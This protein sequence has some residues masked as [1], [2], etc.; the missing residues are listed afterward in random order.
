MY[1]LIYIYIYIDCEDGSI[2]TLSVSHM[3][4]WPINVCQFGEK[5]YMRHIKEK[6]AVWTYLNGT[7]T[8]CD[9]EGNFWAFTTYLEDEE[10][11]R[12]TSICGKCKNWVMGMPGL[13]EKCQ[14]STCT[15][16]RYEECEVCKQPTNYKF[17]DRD[18]KWKY[19]YDKCEGNITIGMLSFKY[20]GN[21][22]WQCHLFGSYTIYIYIYIGCR[23]G[24]MPTVREDEKYGE[25]S[26]FYCKDYQCDGIDDYMISIAVPGTPGWKE[27]YIDICVIP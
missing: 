9:Q 14:R 5:D 6:E 23:D 20:K 22:G 2:L 13:L 19:C 10:R 3:D 12:E 4:D 15:C 25:Y 16:G 1:I 11:A 17:I 8:K 24:L 27:F 26:D 18:G 7:C 21:N